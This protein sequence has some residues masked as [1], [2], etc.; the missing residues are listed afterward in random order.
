MMPRACVAIDEAIRMAQVRQYQLQQEQR[1]FD[2]GQPEWWAINHKLDMV[3]DELNGPRNSGG[4]LLDMQRLCPQQLA[5]RAGSGYE[6][7]CAERCGR[8]SELVTDVGVTLEYVRRALNNLESQARAL[9]R[10]ARYP[11]V[12]RDY[13]QARIFGP[14]LT[15][16]TA[17][18]PVYNYQLRIDRWSF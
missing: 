13:G 17:G 15:A 3:N 1:G 4:G 8:W 11:C 10:G 12:I 18:A 2:T 5:M 16:A 6:R 7:E 9:S 14:T